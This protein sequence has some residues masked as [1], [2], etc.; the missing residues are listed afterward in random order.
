MKF[1]FHYTFSGFS[2]SYLIGP[3]EGGDAILIDPGLF[4]VAMLKS[5]EENGFDLRY[6]LITHAHDSHINGLKTILKIYSPVL[7]SANRRIQN[8]ISEATHEGQTLKLGKFS[9]NVLETPGH[10]P[11]SV[12]YRIGRHLFTGDTLYAGS[13]GICPDVAS[14]ALLIS[15]IREKI[16]VQGDDCT[17][18]PGHGPPSTVGIERRMNPAVQEGC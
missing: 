18:F 4:D 8:Q 3:D 15:S 11:D 9:I 17:V 5:V 6:I 13:V 1:F 2:N 7:F 10:S 14:R 16:L 12:T